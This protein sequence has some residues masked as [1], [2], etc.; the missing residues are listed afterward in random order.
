MEHTPL[1][2]QLLA[3]SPPKSLRLSRVTPEPL[4]ASLHPQLALPVVSPHPQLEL[5]VVSP[6]QHPKLLAA[7]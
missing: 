2:L 1:V 5:L 3:A 6:H 7:L 4:E